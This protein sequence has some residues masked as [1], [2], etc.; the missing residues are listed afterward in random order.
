MVWPEDSPGET[1]VA[2]VGDESPEP[3]PDPPRRSKRPS[4][5]RLVD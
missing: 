4:H 1:A 5:L 3:D 2:P